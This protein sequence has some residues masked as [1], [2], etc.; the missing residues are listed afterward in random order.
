MNLQFPYIDIL[1]DNNEVFADIDRFIFYPGMEFGSEVKWWPDRG[2]RP[3]LHEG[4][5]F[6]YYLNS[7]GKEK[8]ATPEFMVPVMADGR[9]LNICD[10]Y[11]GQT[12]FLDHGYDNPQRFL[13]IYAHIVP[14]KDLKKGDR[15]QSGEV[16]ATIADTTGRKNRMPAHLHL[17]LMYAE[18]EIPAEKFDWDLMHYDE[19]TNLIDP[20]KMI[21]SDHIEFRNTNHW[22][23][24]YTF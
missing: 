7:S 1:K 20:F 22:K 12:V 15:I 9:V 10:D 24:Q 21:I 18:R 6:C 14:D 23:E 13:S 17:S 2:T 3:T 4:V 19:R 16:I 11:L 5:D 8:I